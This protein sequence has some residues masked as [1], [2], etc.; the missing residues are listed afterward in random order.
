MPTPMPFTIIVL[1]LLLVASAIV[2]S[3]KRARLAQFLA[4]TMLF[5]GIAALSLCFL[6]AGTST[7]LF[8][9]FN[10]YP[11][12]LFFMM[13]LS[14]GMLLVNALSYRY[15]NDYTTL[16]LLLGFSF[17]GMVLVSTSVSLLSIFLGLE[18]V[19]VST[20]FMIMLGGKRHIEAAVKFF[21][22]SSVSMAVFSFALA[23]VFPYNAGLSLVVLSQNMNISGSYLIAL[24]L[25]LFVAALSFEVAL[26]PFNLWVPDVYQ[27]S[28]SNITAMLAGINKKIS[29]A[30]LMLIIFFVFA[31]Y[32]SIFSLLFLMLSVATMF[33]GNIV[34]LVQTDV[35]RLFAYSSIAQAGYIMIGLAVAT[36]FGIEASVLQIFAHSFMII[37]AFAIVLWLESLNIKT[38]SDYTG[39]SGRNRFAALF[40]TILMLSMAGIPPLLGFYGKF[41]L[42]SSAID[43][44]IVI[45]AV[46]GVINSFISVYYYAKLIDVMY[47]PRQHSRIETEWF[48]LGVAL[49]AIIVIVVLGIYP[50]PLISAAISAAKSIISI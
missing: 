17:A 20:T 33:F 32:R 29:F 45:L 6:S 2:S 21:L 10:F 47:M 1:L 31:A 7:V 18:L 26:F 16:S 49:A 23:L 42:F 48:A 8:G 13:L 40:L 28:P 37:G 41:L 25:I 50:Q 11:F 22:L 46:L 39:L 14:T 19:S 27:G 38:I 4:S 24:S 12:S 34:A 5:A 44:N 3:V 35:K 36:Q 30:A 15:S 43:A 9:V